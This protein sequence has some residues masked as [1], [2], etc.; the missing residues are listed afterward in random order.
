MQTVSSMTMTPADPGATPRGEGLE[1]HQDVHLVGPQDRH[2]GAAGDHRLQGVVLPEHPA[3]VLVDQ[4][5]Q[6]NPQGNS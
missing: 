6:R 5:P 1:V 2:R 4:L 3:G